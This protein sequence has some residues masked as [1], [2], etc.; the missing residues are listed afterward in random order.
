M[1]DAVILVHFLNDGVGNAAFVGMT[2]QLVILWPTGQQRI[3]VAI[4]QN[5]RPASQILP[6][7]SIKLG[8]DINGY[9]HQ[10]EP[11]HISI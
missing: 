5:R 6:Q 7:L 10:G 4:E 9:A 3:I 11:H 1:D 8:K 2:D